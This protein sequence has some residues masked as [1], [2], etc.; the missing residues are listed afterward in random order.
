MAAMSED[1]KGLKSLAHLILDN[2]DKVKVQEFIK[3]FLLEH[4]VVNSRWK[5][6]ALMQALFL[7]S[8]CAHQVKLV[9][10]LWQLWPYVP[11]AGS[12]AEH[13]V[14]ILGYMT[15]N[16]EQLKANDVSWDFGV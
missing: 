10:I 16:N 8:D 11:M 13:F 14:D 7:T 4:P 12:R 6:H 1:E 3:K 5:A 9:K 2:V 15:L